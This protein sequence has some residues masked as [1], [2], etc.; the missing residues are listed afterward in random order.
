MRYDTPIYFRSVNRVY[1]ENTGDYEE[2]FSEVEMLASVT[3]VNKE[4]FAILFGHVP[5]K[6]VKVQI[7]THYTEH[8]D[9]IRIG[10]DIYEVKATKYLRQKQAMVLEA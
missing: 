7:Q 10:D 3:D 5:K 1:N 8:F 6:A 4:R 9:N 2:S